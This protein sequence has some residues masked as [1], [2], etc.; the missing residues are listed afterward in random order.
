MTKK[1]P[2]TRGGKRPGAGRPP[3]P[4]GTKTGA[5]LK[6]TAD[7]QAFLLTTGNKNEYVDNL[8]RATKQF[9]EW[10]TTNQKGD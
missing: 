8:I 1:K 2:E 4:R 3:G 5:G 6:L 10:T 7:V 9:R